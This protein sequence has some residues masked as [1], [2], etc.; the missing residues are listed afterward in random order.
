M[1]GNRH[2]IGASI[3]IERFVNEENQHSIQSDEQL[4][5]TLFFSDA[6]DIT[7]P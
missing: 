3:R 5:I 6:F 4:R 2:F 1:G 7:F